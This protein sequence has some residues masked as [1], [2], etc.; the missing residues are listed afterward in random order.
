MQAARRA[1]ISHYNNG[2][3]MIIF[4]DPRTLIC[5]SVCCAVMK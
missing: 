2:S 3:Y 4:P 5:V 1:T